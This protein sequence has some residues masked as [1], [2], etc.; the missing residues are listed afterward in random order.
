MV[1]H[2]AAFQ[3][4]RALDHAAPALVAGTAVIARNVTP[5]FAAAS[6]ADD[7]DQDIYDEI[8]DNEED[9]DS[10]DDGM[11]DLEDCETGAGELSFSNAA[12]LILGRCFGQDR[13][14]WSS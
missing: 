1:G 2:R 3:L 12:S 11:Y 5:P 6:F 7:V 13:K 8:E 14:V 10:W 9:D 4:L